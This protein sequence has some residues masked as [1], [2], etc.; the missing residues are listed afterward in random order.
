MVQVVVL[1][2]VTEVMEVVVNKNVV[3]YFVVEIEM[4]TWV[5]VEEQVVVV[6]EAM[7]EQVDLVDMV[8]M[9]QVG[10]RLL[11]VVMEVEEMLEIFT[12][13]PLVVIY[14]GDLVVVEQVVVVEHLI[15]AQME[16]PVAMVEV[17]L[18]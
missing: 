5:E 13:L 15:M 17:L 18:S 12:A 2:E 10:L 3:V 1:L 14:I 9:V 7:G 6:V 4:A 16:D 8:L 11:E